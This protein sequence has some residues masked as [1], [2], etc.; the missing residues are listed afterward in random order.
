MQE[1]RIKEL[2]AATDRH[3]KWIRDLEID[4]NKETTRTRSR[5]NALEYRAALD[6]RSIQS[7]NRQAV[8]WNPQ[9]HGLRSRVFSV[10]LWFVGR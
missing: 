9:E 5:L 7:L 1:Q 2:L 4:F 6:K 3:R 8:G 10:L